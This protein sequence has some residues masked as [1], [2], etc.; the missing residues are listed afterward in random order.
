MIVDV[1]TIS[2]DIVAICCGIVSA[3]AMASE[4]VAME[5]LTLPSIECDEVLD[6]MS[7]AGGDSVLSDADS[8]SASDAHVSPDPYE[9]TSET[10]EDDDDTVHD[11]G[12]VSVVSSDD[13]TPNESLHVFLCLRCG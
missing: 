6:V 7:M 8:A 12:D 5:T 4:D 13:R 10:S 11:G 2:V 1:V 9:W 3:Q